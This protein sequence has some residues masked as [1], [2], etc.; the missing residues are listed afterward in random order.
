MEIRRK[1]IHLGCAIFPLAY[2]FYLSR[3]QILLICVTITVL[4]L[5]AEVLRFYN[6]FGS[7]WFIKI[8]FPL[9]R[10]DEKHKNLTG[11]TW[12]FIA[13]TLAFVLFD[14][15]AAVPA[16]LILTIADSS[17][18]L[19][20]KGIGKNQI[21]GKKTWEGSTAFFLVCLAVIYFFVPQANWS[22]VLITGIVSLVEVLPLP[23]N[24]NLWIT[25]S[26]GLLITIFI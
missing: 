15:Q 10:E 26:A 17:A 19:V 1:L 23:L 14:K 3:E 22:I 9:L 12:L 4:F 24:D 8:F 21:V 13:T 6:S 20:G 5:I 2:A 16:V 7:K 25:F 11:A 18:A